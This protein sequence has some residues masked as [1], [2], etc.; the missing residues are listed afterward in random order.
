MASCTLT[1]YLDFSSFRLED[2]LLSIFESSL[3]LY[4][5][6]SPPS[7]FDEEFLEGNPRQLLG[8]TIASVLSAI[9]ERIKTSKNIPIKSIFSGILQDLLPN[10]NHN[11]RILDAVS[12][13]LMSLDKLEIQLQ[14]D[15]VYELIKEYLLSN[16]QDL[17]VSALTVL[18][19]FENLICRSGNPPEFKGF[20]QV[21]E[22]LL[23][24]EA[25]KN[26]V[27]NIRS[28]SMAMKRLEQLFSIG[29]LDGIYEDAIIRAF[30]GYLTIQF[31]PLWQSSCQ[32]LSA[33]ASSSSKKFWEVFYPFFQKSQGANLPQS[34]L[35]SVKLNVESD[36]ADEVIYQSIYSNR[37]VYPFS[38]QV[39]LPFCRVISF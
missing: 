1:K 26:D 15:T 20:R 38:L 35:L 10:S 17:R 18:V 6:V 36:L 13:F 27:S 7:S 39:G 25:M 32:M 9:S 29:G 14:T 28:K 12:T 2:V 31:T 16:S 8:S 33:M 24:I 5:D 3:I 4:K 30:L 23:V 22:P 34:V 11:Y 37:Q 19:Q 21:F